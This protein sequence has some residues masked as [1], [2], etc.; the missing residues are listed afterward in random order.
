MLLNFYG[1]QYHALSPYSDYQTWRYLLDLACKTIESKHQWSL[2]MQSL[3]PRNFLVSRLLLCLIIDAQM[4]KQKLDMVL[5]RIS[6]QFHH[7]KLRVMHAGLILAGHAQKRV[8]FINDNGIQLVQN[9]AACRFGAF[10]NVYPQIV[11]TMQKAITK[12]IDWCKKIKR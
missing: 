3:N 11:K 8:N 12:C 6:I 4:L 9:E 2:K 5:A 7:D 10:Q 1:Y